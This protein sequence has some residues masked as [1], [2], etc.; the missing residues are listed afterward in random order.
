MSLRTT[1]SSHRNGVKLL[2]DLGVHLW[3]IQN[4]ND[5]SDFRRLSRLGRPV[6]LLRTKSCGRSFYPQLLLSLFS[7]SKLDGRD[8][9]T[10]ALVCVSMWCFLCFSQR[11]IYDEYEKYSPHNDDTVDALKMMLTVSDFP[12]NEFKGFV[13]EDDGEGELHDDHPFIDA[14]RCYLEDSLESEKEN[15]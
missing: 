14:Q 7:N 12:G 15:S 6:G 1:K 13:E 8:Q 3:L 5:L 11:S 10:K 9:R 2:S 4:N